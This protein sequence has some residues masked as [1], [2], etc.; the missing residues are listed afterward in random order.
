MFPELGERVSNIQPKEKLKT[1]FSILKRA[2]FSC[3]EDLAGS[4]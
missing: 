2:L 4:L 3:C 1:S